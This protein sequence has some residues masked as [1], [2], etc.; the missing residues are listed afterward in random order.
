M[1]NAEVSSRM[2]DNLKK[3]YPAVHDKL[4]REGHGERTGAACAACSI[5][6]VSSTACS[7]ITFQHRSRDL[8][9]LLYT[10]SALVTRRELMLP[11]GMT[12]REAFVQIIS[13]FFRGISTAKGLRLIDDNLKRYE[14]TK[15]GK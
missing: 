11:A 2:M 4:T 6:R 8:G 7:S 13:N 15:Y 14:L 1:D 12:E 3:F 5:S 10:A 9:A